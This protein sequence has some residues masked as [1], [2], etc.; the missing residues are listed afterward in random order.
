VGVVVISGVATSVSGEGGVVDLVLVSPIV[1]VGV[2]T[3][4]ATVGSSDIN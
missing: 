1:I 2:V 3:D 4:G